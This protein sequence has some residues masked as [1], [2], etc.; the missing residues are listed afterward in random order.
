MSYIPV[1]TLRKNRKRR[2]FPSRHTPPTSPHTHSSTQCTLSAARHA[3]VKEGAVR[4]V[5]S[6]GEPHFSL[7]STLWLWQEVCSH[8]M[9]DIELEYEVATTGVPLLAE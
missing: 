3:W 8:L 9:P 2:Q 1:P 6:G 7:V 4:R 5:R